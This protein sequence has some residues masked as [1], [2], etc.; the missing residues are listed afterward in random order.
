[1][2]VDL[3]SKNLLS[4]STFYLCT[5]TCLQHICVVR[6]PVFNKYD[7]RVDLSSA[8]ILNVL[9][10]LQQVY[11]E[12]STC[13]QLFDIWI[14]I[15]RPDKYSTNI[16]IEYILE[17][18]KTH[19]FSHHQNQRSNNLPLFDDGNLWVMIFNNFYFTEI[20]FKLYWQRH[21]NNNDSIW[22][23]E[24]FIHFSEE[25]RSI[26]NTFQETFHSY[27]RRRQYIQIQKHQRNISKSPYMSPP[28]TS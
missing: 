12:V 25:D 15:I 6:R 17:L 8:S 10:C 27:L 16:K 20:D 19:N 14:S 13:L 26:N 23:K 4:T 5:S 11:F 9:A 7:K 3:S 2:H 1:M 21:V 22:R 28:L 24:S 18:S